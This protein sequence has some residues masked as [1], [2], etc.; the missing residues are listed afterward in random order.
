MT[1]ID[2]HQRAESADLSIYHVVDGDRIEVTSGDDIKK[3]APRD[4]SLL[5]QISVGTSADMERAIASAVQ[6]YKDRRWRGLPLHERQEVL[7]KLADLVDAHQETFAIYESLDA[8][9]PI[10]QALGEVAM[11]SGVLRESADDAAKLFSPYLS[12]GGYC[13]YHLRKPVGVVGAITPWN[14]PLVIAA[15]KIG[16]ALIMGNSLI[17]K[18]SEYTCLSASFLASLALEAGLPPGVLN[19]V[20]GAGHTV[21]ATLA[22]HNLVDLLS[23][24]GSS[25]V[26]KQLQITAGQSNMKRL[27]LECGGK[28]PYIVF[29]DCSTD[30]EAVA[31]DIVGLAFQNQSQNCLAASR[32]LIHQDLKDALLP[33]VIAQTGQLIPQ[34]PLNP[35]SNFGAMINEA[36]MNKVLAYIDSGQKEG[37]KLVAGGR[38]AHL[39][40]D[41]SELRGFYIE[42]TIFSDVLPH[43]KIAQ[44]EIFGPVLSVLTFKDEQEAIELANNSCY[45]LGAYIATQNIGRAQRVS[46][47]VRAGTVLVIGEYT[48]STCYL[49]MGKE[50][51]RESGFGPEG[52]LL[53]LTSYSVSTS[54]HQ[55]T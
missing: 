37:A 18:P 35:S 11:A 32:L 49:E 39:S 17:L 9:K 22:R 25:A 43:Y 36:H 30:L 16:P 45:G 53:G 42:P 26:G 46:Q 6:T 38:R 15:A 29:D 33:K 31:A 8:G 55:W 44:E 41:N 19:V 52:G 50:G 40:N 3:Y 21:G 34:D 2:W 47:E 13:T 5:Y 24:T 54:V 7:T 10:T 28:S 51:Q 27:L 4:G 12:D 23:F 20:V 14:Y 1:T 48:P